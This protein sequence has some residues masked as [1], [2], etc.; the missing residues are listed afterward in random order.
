MSAGPFER[1]LLRVVRAHGLE[2]RVTLQSFDHRVLVA[3]ASI[4][5]DVQRAAL[6]A[7]S[8][9]DYVAVA[10]AAK[11]D[12]ISPNHHWITAEDVSAM[13]A[14]NIRVVPWTVNR[15]EDW[16][17]MVALGVD[18]IITDDPEACIKHLKKVARKSA[19]KK[20]SRRR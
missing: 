9:P 10:R 2:S 1:E 5:P 15:P 17:R 13:H 12:I 3:A 6:V 7:E 8:R 18:A 11:A 20:R 19:K 16:T 14:A 4:A